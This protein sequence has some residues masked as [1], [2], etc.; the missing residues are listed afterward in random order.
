MGTDTDKTGRSWVEPI[1]V[2]LA[3]IAPSLVPSQAPAD[4]ITWLSSG[5]VQ[6]F[7]QGALLM[8]SIGA[9]GRLRDYGIMRPRSG[10]AL[11]AGFL[12]G[13][14]L[15][16]ARL[17]A[18]FMSIANIDSDSIATVLPGSAGAPRAL[19]IIAAALFSL[20]VAYREE[21]FYRIYIVHALKARGAG[22][23]AAILVSTC[24]FAAGHAYQGSA[25]ILSA[26]LVGATLATAANKGFKLHALALAHAVYDFGV[27]MAA[28]GLAGGS[29]R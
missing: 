18:V 25:G 2:T 8:V 26:L 20:A 29:G 14:M 22:S 24:L 1:I 15:L 27:L 21:L 11:R 28:L 12:L 5:A 10:D 17:V 3:M 19:I 23:L 4:I 13:A 6:S 9:S 16:I 7:S